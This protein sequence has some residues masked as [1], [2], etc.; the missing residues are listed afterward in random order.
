MSRLINPL[1]LDRPA[2]TVSYVR[3]FARV[4]PAAGN[5]PSFPEQLVAASAPTSTQ[6]VTNPAAVRAPQNILPEA[7]TTGIYASET[8]EATE[9]VADEESSSWGVDRR[10]TDVGND[11]EDF[12]FD[13]F[14]DIINP[15]QHIP[16]LSTV[17]REMTGE[18]IKPVAR[19]AGDVLFGALTGSLLLS[20]IASIVGAAIEQHTGEEPTI[21]IAQALFDFDNGDDEIEAVETRLAQAD[22]AVDESGDYPDYAKAASAAGGVGPDVA[23]AMPAS[24]RLAAVKQPYGGVMDVAAATARQPAGQA[25]AGASGVSGVAIGDTI[26]TNPSMSHAARLAALKAAKAAPPVGSKE[27]VAPVPLAALSVPGTPSTDDGKKLG[28]M[29]WQSAEATPSGGNPLPPELVRDMMLMAL[30]KY[31]TA[32]NLAPSEMAI[33]G[34]VYR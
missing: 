28:Q 17:Y 14:L 4:A 8:P 1:L 24:N 22:N 31:Q 30:D 12:G 32:S 16:I 34:D 20:G 13:D 21:Q 6:A 25:P 33:G 2:N 5:G 10:T 23:D 9:A 18:S 15:L 7:Q 11:D 27:K 3:D 19:I 29:M 26:H